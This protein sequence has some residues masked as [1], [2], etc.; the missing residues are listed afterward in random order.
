MPRFLNLIP[1]LPI[2]Y[3]SRLALQA[4]LTQTTFR[5]FYNHSARITA[6][7]SLAADIQKTPA[8]ITSTVV[9]RHRAR[10]SCPRFIATVR[11]RTSEN[12]AP[13]FLAACML[14]AL[15]SNW[16]TCHNILRDAQ[17]EL[18]T[19]H[20]FLGKSNVVRKL[21]HLISSVAYTLLMCA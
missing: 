14:W 11:A 8:C 17:F 6:E 9:W 13:V 16:S 3:L 19:R 5:V 7:N 20:L 15:P 12:S 4:P 10:L 21:N 2:S 18:E 1:L